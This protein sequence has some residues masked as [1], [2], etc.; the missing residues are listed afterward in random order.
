[1]EANVRLILD[2]YNVLFQTPL[3]VAS[4]GQND[5]RVGRARLIAFTSLVVPT[6][7]L[8]QTIIVF[9]SKRERTEE[10]AIENHNSGIRIAYAS[11]F[12]E[13]DQYIEAMIAES[14]YPKQLEVV[15]SDGKIRSTAQYYASKTIDAKEWY[16]RSLTRI[17]VKEQVWIAKGELPESFLLPASTKSDST[18][19]RTD[20]EDNMPLD[21]ISDEELERLMDFNE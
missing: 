17:P 19:A 5:Y 16:Y 7:I 14:A 4:R 9:D 11:N 13:A 21:E 2:G 20:Q 6:P 18:L 10:A 12:D 15:T 1:M 3:L 8:S